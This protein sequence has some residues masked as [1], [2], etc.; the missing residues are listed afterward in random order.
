MT[1]V[2]QVV[3]KSGKGLEKVW[4][5]LF[6]TCAGTLWTTSGDICQR[7]GGQAWP[8]WKIRQLVHK[9]NNALWT[10]LP[11]R[12]PGTTYD[13]SIRQRLCGIYREIIRAFLLMHWSICYFSTLEPQNQGR[14]RSASRPKL[15]ATVRG[16]PSTSFVP[17]FLHMWVDFASSFTEFL[18]RISSESVDGNRSIWSSSYRKDRELSA[19]LSLFKSVLNLPVP[20]EQKLSKTSSIYFCGQWHSMHYVRYDSRL[21]FVSVLCRKENTP[22]FIEITCFWFEKFAWQALRS[23]LLRAKRV[24]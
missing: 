10:P 24:T 22:L 17:N 19:D 11:A 8:S 20:T 12:S 14:P 4:K 15:P 16:R 9:S 5:F 2:G 21:A 23:C 6:K 13:L 1:W 18:I 7:F 3:K